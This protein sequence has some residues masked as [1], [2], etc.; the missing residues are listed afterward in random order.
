MQP[1]QQAFETL[2]TLPARAG[3]Q[4]L[5]KRAGDTSAYIRLLTAYQD[6]L[7][8][9]ATSVTWQISPVAGA[10]RNGKTCSHSAQEQ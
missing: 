8:P 9:R 6:M 3:P 10:V 2:H 7:L 4:Q 5:K 1:S